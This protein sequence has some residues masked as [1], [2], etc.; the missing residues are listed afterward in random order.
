MPTPFKPMVVLVLSLCACGHSS[1]GGAYAGLDGS[2]KDAGAHDDSAADAAPAGDD[3]GPSP[4]PEASI[5]ADAG[6]D[7]EDAGAVATLCVGLGGKCKDSTTCLCGVGS[8]CTFDN[9]DCTSAGVCA[10]S[11]QVPLDAGEECCAECQSNYD[12]CT[13]SSP[14][15]LSAWTTCNDA[16][17]GECPVLCLAAEGMPGG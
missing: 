15:C 2:V 4:T 11:F 1:P 13:T 9:V 3:G 17:S 10:V 6:A 5:A 12:A 7:A 8:A 14:S 16:C